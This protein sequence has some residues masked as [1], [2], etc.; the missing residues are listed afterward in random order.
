MTARIESPLRTVDLDFQG[1]ADEEKGIDIFALD[2]KEEQYEE[3]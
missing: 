2:Y 1:G 3:Q